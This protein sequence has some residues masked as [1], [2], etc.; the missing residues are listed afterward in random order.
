MSH[1]LNT[2]KAGDFT[3]GK[4]GQIFK[5]VFFDNNTTVI[6]HKQFGECYM[7]PKER[8]K[9]AVNFVLGSFLDI[10]I[11][12]SGGKLECFSGA[13]LTLSDISIEYHDEA[14]RLFDRNCEGLQDDFDFFTALEKLVDCLY[15]NDG[16]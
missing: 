4:M 13:N 10:K 15:V 11:K 3:S 5:D 6:N 1:Y 7:I 16:R 9:E 2:Y 14:L 8:M 12:E